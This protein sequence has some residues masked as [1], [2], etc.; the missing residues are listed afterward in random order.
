[1]EDAGLI[2]VHFF[3]SG[4]ILLEIVGAISLILGYKTRF[5]AAALLI[6]LIPTTIIFHNPSIDPEQLTHFM[7]NLTIIGGLLMVLGF[8]PGIFSLDCY[9]GRR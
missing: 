3:L 6:F 9:F 5:G 8:G 4:A 1:M 7:K 2:L